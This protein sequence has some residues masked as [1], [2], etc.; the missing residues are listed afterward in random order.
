MHYIDN[1]SFYNPVRI[2]YGVKK[3][4]TLP[5]LIS[6]KKGLLVT[7]PGFTRRGLTERLQSILA[8]HQ[9][10][11]LD[12]VKPN[13]DLKDIEAYWQQYREEDIQYVIGV[14]GGSVLDTAKALGYLL[15]IKAA[16]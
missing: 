15:R 4:E 14:G 12:M 8:D 7:T 9:L 11:I 2:A 5:D 3:I 1:W 10:V 13:P 6:A 16:G